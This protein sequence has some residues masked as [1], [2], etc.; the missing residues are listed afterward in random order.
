[1]I[2]RTPPNYI[3]TFLFLKVATKAWFTPY[4]NLPS[5]QSQALVHTNCDEIL[6]LYFSSDTIAPAFILT[7]KDISIMHLL[8]L[9]LH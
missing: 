5:H 9:F 7:I 1:M 6:S 4:S 8:R 3:G 2:F